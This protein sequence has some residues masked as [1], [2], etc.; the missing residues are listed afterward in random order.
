MPSSRDHTSGD[1]GYFYDT[2]HGRVA[3]Q[4]LPEDLH[5]AL[6]AA[7]SSQAIGRLTRIS[8]LGQTSL[9]Y[10][11][12]TQT[13]FS[14]AIG[15]L[16]VMNSLT[17]HLW[18]GK[19]TPRA[20]IDEVQQHFPAALK[21]SREKLTAIKCHLLLAAL[22]QDCGELPFQ[23]VTSLYFR[24]HQRELQ[25]LRSEIGDCADGL[26]SKEVFTLRAL[27]N[28][29]NT[30]DELKKFDFGFLAYLIT[31]RCSFK[32]KQLG[33]LR[34]MMDGPIDADRLD[35]VYRDA[36]LTIGSVSRTESVLQSIV[37]YEPDCVVVN[38]PRPAVDFLSTRAR[39]WTFVYTSPD[40][41]FRHALLKSLLQ[42]GLG[43][44]EGRKLFESKVFRGS[45][46][47]SDFLRTDDH[48]LLDGLRK[49]QVDKDY[50]RLGETGTVACDN[51]LKNVTDYEVRI[52]Q[53]PNGEVQSE[54]EV[55]ERLF[56]DLLLDHEEPHKIYAPRSVRVSQRLTKSVA[57][58]VPLE[59][60]S[61]FFSPVFSAENR[62]PLMRNSFFV[63]I[64]H[65]IGV[66]T[67]DKLESAISANQL[68]DALNR[69]DVSREIG[70]LDD[71]WNHQGWKGCRIAVSCSFADRPTIVRVIH[72]LQSLKQQYRVLLDSLLQ[73]DL[74]T[75]ESSRQ[76]IREADAI[77]VI[78][79]KHYLSR[80]T[81]NAKTHIAMEV[82]TINAK[83][84]N[85]NKA[86]VVVL[87]V[88]ASEELLRFKGWNWVT[89]NPNWQTPPLIKGNLRYVSDDSLARD[90][91][92]AVN[93]LNSP[94]SRSL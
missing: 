69:E 41:R 23:R 60:C 5:A 25:S 6:R 20:I 59:D 80:A 52:L 12:A 38:D 79:S 48:S 70:Y 43:T 34:Q 21:V 16:L 1:I 87:G 33:Q 4:D 32:A 75:H 8:Q 63:F 71:T 93:T 39:L 36:L 17:K 7:L 30:F 64:P 74:S 18:G 19:K 2:I 27:S 72:A 78:A 73:R 31:G 14:H 66:A 55:P 83:N 94:S 67:R 77:L 9:T 84:E 81:E 56:F 91:K 68:Y 40:V 49:L 85:G 88:D 82:R 47:L 62:I 45:L 50:A 44:V 53:K 15:T 57:K 76:L 26:S 29:I 86:P 42:A 90:V 22:Y 37:R 10:F 61:G 46:N 28:D 89:M 58:E 3:F 51:L 92:A 11:S 13:R 35:Y 24:P 54:I 65:D